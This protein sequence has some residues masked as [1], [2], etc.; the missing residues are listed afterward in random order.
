M[1]WEVVFVT[2]FVQVM[3]VSADMDGALFLE[4]ENQIG[5]PSGVFYVIHKT[6]LLELIDFSFDSLS[7]G[8]INGS[9]LLTDKI[10]IW[11]CIDTLFNNGGIKSR[12][13]LNR[14]R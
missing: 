8:R 3:K 5:H 10:G 12:K 6:N 7:S 11:P 2:S 13:F 1:V 4:N 14:T 9:Q